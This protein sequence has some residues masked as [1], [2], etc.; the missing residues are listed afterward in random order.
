MQRRDER[1]VP[2]F[3]GL[4]D[5]HS[6][7]EPGKPDHQ[8]LPIDEAKAESPDFGRAQACLRLEGDADLILQ[9]FCIVKQPLQLVRGTGG[10]AAWAHLHPR[11]SA[12]V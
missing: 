4:G 2:G 3:A 5:S 10:S 6:Q 8:F 7:I 9:I 1:D 12:V 11:D